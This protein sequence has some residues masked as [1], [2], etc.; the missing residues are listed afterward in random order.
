MVIMKKDVI[1]KQE[2]KEQVNLFLGTN[3]GKLFWAENNIVD[4]QESESPDFLL[5]KNDET[6]YALEVTQFIAENKNKQYSQAL[7]RYGNNLCNYAAEHYGIKVSILIDKYDPRKFSP[8]WS[9]HLDYA[10]N[11]GFSKI[12]PKAAFNKEL[13][14]ILTKNFDNL[15]S[16][17]LVQEC[18][19]IEDDYFKI[20]IDP[21]ICP[22]TNK[23]DCIV[24]NIGMAAIDPIQELQKRI[25]EKNIKIDK[26]KTNST[27]CFLL[28][29]V[30]D[31]R[32]G[33]YYF[34]SEK[35][36]KHKFNSKFDNIFIY[37]EKTKKSYILNQ[38]KSKCSIFRIRF[39][40]CFNAK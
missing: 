33:N 31:T 2:E 36:F 20:S 16:G 3:I 27:K 17:K 35:L 10:Y 12:P 11:P 4:I 40:T 6:K 1:K 25:D 30:P 38:S 7:I 34:F 26:Y 5:I 39:A 21:F 24:N 22:W 18:I 23:Y 29:Y 14:N 32:C 13:K 28:I 15:K 37:E 9:D 8:K 19:K